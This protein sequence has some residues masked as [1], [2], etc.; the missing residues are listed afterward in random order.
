MY[1]LAYLYASSDCSGVSS[2]A[3][4]VI[5]TKFQLIRFARM[6]SNVDDFNNRDL[7]LTTKLLKQGY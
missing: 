7:F 5:K 6:C 2:Q 4:N 1:L 3:C